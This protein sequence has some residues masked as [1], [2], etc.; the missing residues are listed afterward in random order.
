MRIFIGADIACF[1]DNREATRQIRGKVNQRDEASCQ[2]YK[3]V[4]EKPSI[5]TATFSE[6]IK[7]STVPQARA[8]K[9]LCPTPR[10]DRYGYEP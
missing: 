6:Q 5:A 3:R 10:S 7:M 9:R 2:T 4:R 1:S 8:A